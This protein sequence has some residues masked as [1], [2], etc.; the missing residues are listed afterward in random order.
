MQPLLAQM[1]RK[2]IRQKGVNLVSLSTFGS[3]QK[4]GGTACAPCR[5]SSV[6]SV[7]VLRLLAGT[8]ETCLGQQD[9]IAF[10]Q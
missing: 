9:H 10:L 2:V 1:P 6:C 3:G 5:L 8:Q 7:S 4:Q